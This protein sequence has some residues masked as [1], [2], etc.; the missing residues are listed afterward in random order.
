MAKMTEIN[1]LALYKCIM[2][3]AEEFRIDNEKIGIVGDSA[4]ASIAALICNNY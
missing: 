1:V 2:E 3:S 4:G